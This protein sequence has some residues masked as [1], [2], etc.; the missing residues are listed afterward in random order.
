MNQDNFDKLFQ[1]K[2]Q[3]ILEIG[4]GNGVYTILLRKHNEVTPIGIEPYNL[5]G[6]IQADAHNLPF[7]NNSFDVVF[8]G[9]VLHHLKDLDKAIKEFRRVLK[10]EGYYYGIE[11]NGKWFNFFKVLVKIIGLN[12]DRNEKPIYSKQVKEVFIENNFDIN[13]SFMIDRIP[14]IRDRLMFIRNSHLSTCMIIEAKKI[15]VKK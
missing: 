5:E 4:C 6:F 15:V 10:P 12:I 11:P 9:F 8:G 13:I 7:K 3:K 14:F 2:N 1:L